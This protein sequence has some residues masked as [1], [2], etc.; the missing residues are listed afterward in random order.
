MA[1]KFATAVENLKVSRP[2]PSSCYCSAE[3]FTS[4]EASWGLLELG[5]DPRAPTTR[6]TRSKRAA[7]TGVANAAALVA[8]I[9]ANGV[10]MP[11]SPTPR[12]CTLYWRCP[13]GLAMLDPVLDVKPTMANWIMLI[14]RIGTAM[15]PQDMLLSPAFDAG[16]PW[17]LRVDVP[18]QP[19]G[20]AR[21]C[22]PWFTARLYRGHA[23]GGRV[24][25]V[26][27]DRRGIDRP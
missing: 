6:C 18:D 17:R 24:G 27:D 19:G 1:E 23:G 7:S 8:R 21:W 10:W 20:V 3:V 4:P 15:A 12:S 25:R 11:I 26:S 13:L 22:V 14:A 16:Q 5:A 9:R 2:S